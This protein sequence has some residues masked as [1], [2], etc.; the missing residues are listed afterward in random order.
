MKKKLRRDIQNKWI[1]GVLAGAARYFG[2][3]ALL[4]RIGAIA[5]A[6]FSVFVPAAVVYLIAWVLIPADTSGV[7]PTN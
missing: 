7:E 4:F 6:V 3:D 5:L 1:G 2:H